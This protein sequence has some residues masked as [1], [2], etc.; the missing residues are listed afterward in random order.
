M[1][2]VFAV[3]FSFVKALPHL[4]LTYRAVFSVPVA[5]LLLTVSDMVDYFNVMSVFFVLLSSPCLVSTVV[6]LF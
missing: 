3:V 2:D 6:Y 5:T 4:K 1:F